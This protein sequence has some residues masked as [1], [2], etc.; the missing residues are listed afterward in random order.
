MH[1]DSNHDPLTR[2]I[3]ALNRQALELIA[4]YS[5]SNPEDICL[6]LNIS[7]TFMKAV[8]G[9]SSES[10]GHIA[11]LGQFILQPV[12]EPS[13]LGLC[14][15]LNPDQARAHLRSVTRLKHRG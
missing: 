5:S 6:K 14:A 8:N 3:A 7:Q 15:N 10:I 13:S 12:I 1:S 9:L 2:D 11:G 4:R